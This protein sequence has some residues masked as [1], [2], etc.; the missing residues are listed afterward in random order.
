LWLRD[1]GPVFLENN[2]AVNFNFNGWGDKQK[3]D[4]DAKVAKFICEFSSTK[5]VETFLVLEGGSIEVDGNGTAI[6]TESCSLNNNRNPN[7]RK[8]DIEEELYRLLGVEKVIWL[9]GIRGL[10]ITDG[11]T[12]FYARFAGKHKP[13]VVILHSD[14]DDPDTITNQTILEKSSNALSEAIKVVSLC[15]PNPKKVRKG[16]LKR[17]DAALGYVNFYVCNGAVIMPEFGDIEADKNAR[18]VLQNLYVD[19]VI[20]QINIDSIAIGGGGIHC[21]TQQQPK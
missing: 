5:M 20:E 15:S 2:A 11:H 21:C 13:G 16:L 6:I 12:D 10:D 7:V 4:R 19:R 14:P 8:N 3:H 1:T 9:P 18:K 17:E